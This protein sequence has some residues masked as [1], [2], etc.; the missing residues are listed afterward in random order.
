MNTVCLGKANTN[1]VLYAKSVW[2]QIMNELMS[3]LK[4]L[5]AKAKDKEDAV[6]RS[7]KMKLPKDVAAHV[8]NAMLRG[9]FCLTVAYLNHDGTNVHT[10]CYRK[11]FPIGRAIVALEGIKEKLL[12]GE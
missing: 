4:E 6:I 10:I 11:Q 3:D 2:R 12:K 9:R 1:S 7:V 8:S 5:K